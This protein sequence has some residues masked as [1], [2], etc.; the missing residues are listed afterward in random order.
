MKVTYCENLQLSTNRQGAWDGNY[1]SFTVV[2]IAGV[3]GAISSISY[4]VVCLAFLAVDSWPA[5]VV[6]LVFGGTGGLLVVLY[7]LKTG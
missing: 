3:A 2:P 1:N 6:G 7:V 4:C 5:M